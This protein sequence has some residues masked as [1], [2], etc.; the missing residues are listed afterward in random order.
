MASVG[1]NEREVWLLVLQH[2]HRF[3]FAPVARQLE[4]QLLPR[5]LLP[6]DTEVWGARS[7]PLFQALSSRTSRSDCTPFIVPTLTWI[8]ACVRAGLQRCCQLNART[9]LS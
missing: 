2:L 5:E 4:E 1:V 8:S 7:L 6:R 3:G 9:P